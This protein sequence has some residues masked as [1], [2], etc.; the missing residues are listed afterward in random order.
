MKHT[1]GI[2]TLL[3]V[4]LIITWESGCSITAMPQP[5]VTPGA[6]K[7][8]LKNGSTNQ[9]EVLEAFGSPNFVTTTKGGGELWVYSNHARVTK[10]YRFGLIGFGGGAP[11]GAVAGGGASGGVGGEGTSSRSIDLMLKFDSTETLTDYTVSQTQY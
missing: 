6:A 7:I 3:V 1:K 10:Y 2:K 4:L 8:F 5:A 11:G 9:A